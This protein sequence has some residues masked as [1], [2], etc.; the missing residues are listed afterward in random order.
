MMFK[1]CQIAIMNMR[2]PLTFQNFL[3]TKYLAVCSAYSDT[4]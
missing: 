1:Y 4:I 2:I 3:Q